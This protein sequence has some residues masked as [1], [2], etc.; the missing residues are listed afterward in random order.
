MEGGVEDEG[1]GDADGADEGDEGLDEDEHATPN[2]TLESNSTHSHHDHDPGSDQEGEAN[3]AAEAEPSPPPPPSPPSPWE[4]ACNACQPPPGDLASL[5]MQGT[6]SDLQLEIE[7]VS[8][9]IPTVSWVTSA[10]AMKASLT[11]M[12]QGER[13]DD[14]VTF[15]KECMYQVLHVMVG[16]N[17][18]EG[19]P[20]TMT[21]LQG[22]WKEK[23]FD[24]FT[25]C[26]HEG[27][28]CAMRVSWAESSW[29]ESSWTA[30]DRVSVALLSTYLQ[31]MP[32]SSSRSLHPHSTPPR[33][34]P[35]SHFALPTPLPSS[36]F[37]GV[38]RSPSIRQGHAPNRCQ[39]PRERAEAVARLAQ[40]VQP[41][42]R[43]DQFGGA[44]LR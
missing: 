21:D 17:S 38:L 10:S 44:A 3:G 31:C 30:F 8:S 23:V 32:L 29:A 12:L 22:M 5:S 39:L 43:V 27:L 18:I 37:L 1:L 13:S 4:A 6:T 40:G 9:K 42:W 26:F 11:L 34:L 16:L 15:A 36:S 2:A 24:K 33:A 14:V 28:A 41:L 20:K 7:E 19:K 35:P 25:S